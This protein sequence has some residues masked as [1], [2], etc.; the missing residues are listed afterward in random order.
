MFCLKNSFIGVLSSICQTKI[1]SNFGNK[2]EKLEKNGHERET[3]FLV[4]F[5]FNCNLFDTRWR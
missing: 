2:W 3:A 1:E 5:N 4:L